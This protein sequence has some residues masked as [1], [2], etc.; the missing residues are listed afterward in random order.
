MKRNW[1]P[2]GRQY[3]NELDMKLAWGEALVQG[4]LVTNAY[5]CDHCGA[6]HL[7]FPKPIPR[8][9]AI[10][11]NKLILDTEREA[12][13]RLDEIARKRASGYEARREIR[14]YRCTRDGG[15]GK[16]HLTSESDWT[17]PWAG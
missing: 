16:W 4:R 3:W 7:G 8:Y 9:C 2:R 14:Y 15:C 11:K 6:W 5:T 12:Q 13:E 10:E 1:C 17:P